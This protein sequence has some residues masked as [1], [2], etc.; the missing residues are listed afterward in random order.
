MLLSDEIILMNVCEIL[1]IY[2]TEIPAQLIFPLLIYL[3][4][5]FLIGQCLINKVGT[6]KH[7]YFG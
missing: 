4:N 5:T 6:Y 7:N 3:N 1:S 2:K